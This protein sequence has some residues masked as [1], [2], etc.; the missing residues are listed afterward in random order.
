MVACALCG[1]SYDASARTFRDI[2]AG[3]VEPRCM[4]HRTRNPR[5]GTI[6]AEH[7]RSWLDGYTDDQIAEMS[8]AFDSYAEKVLRPSQRTD[9]MKIVVAALAACGSRIAADSHD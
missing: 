1:I 9:S 3:R 2:Q 4:L 7:R 8:W 6:K 5:A